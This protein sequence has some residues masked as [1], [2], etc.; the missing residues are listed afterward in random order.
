[1]AEAF[2]LGDEPP[3]VVTGGVALCEPVAAEVVVGLLAVEDVVDGDE[4][5][6]ADGDGG[7]FLAAASSQPPKLRREVGVVGPRRRGGAPGE[8]GA[9]PLRALAGGARTV[10][11]GRTR[12]ETEGSAPPLNESPRGSR[13]IDAHRRVG[14][15]S[16]TPTAAEHG[17]GD[18]DVQGREAL[19]GVLRVAAAPE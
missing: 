6:V 1:V 16:L 3:D 10:F 2:E 19:A 17:L 11:A 8:R 14:P 5:A 18:V 7:A 13:R 4:D 9:Q 12:H 15:G